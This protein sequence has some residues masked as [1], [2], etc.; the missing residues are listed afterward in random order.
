MLSP[1]AEK[2]I[3]DAQANGK[4]ILK[5]ISANDAGI[6]GSHQAG[7]YM[8]KPAWKLYSPFG[9]E[10]GTLRK[11]K[12]KIFWQGERYTDSVVTYYGQK[13]RDEY[14]LTCF[15][16]GFPYLHEDMVGDLLVLIPQDMHNWLA[17]V[18]D[19]GSD[20]DDVQAALGVEIIEGWTIYDAAAK[21]EPVSEDACIDKQFRAFAAPL[22]AFPKGSQFSAAARD[23]MLKCVRDFAK[24]SPDDKLLDLMKEEYHLFKLVER[25]LCLHEVTQPFRTIDGFLKV[26]ATI[27]NRRKSRAGR[28]ME[29]HVEYLLSEAQ[30]PFECRPDI[31][32][33]PDILIPGRDAYND[34]HYPDDK[35]FMLGVKT[36]CKDRW[37]QILN[38]AQRIQHK[39][40]MTIQ[41]GISKK[42]LLQM[43]QAQ[44][45]L[46]VPQRLHSRYPRDKTIKLMDVEGFI[47]AVRRRLAS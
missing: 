5:Y 7:F 24:R 20:I 21:A 12:V 1:I 15:G 13:T 19:A 14:R 47:K 41:E 31:A 38:E 42:Q 4:A 23:A 35:L 29:N 34:S 26:A 17:Y 6:T 39:H 8:P 33:E 37:R 40:L 2:A 43:Q 22:T 10:K 36:T 25:Q 9:P 28:S 16:K 46:I 11:S 3:E 45:T 27:M 30:I 32:G 18:I 44:V